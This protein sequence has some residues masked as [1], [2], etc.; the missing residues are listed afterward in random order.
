MVAQSEKKDIP[1]SIVIASGAGGEFLLRC[2]DFLR[3]QAASPG[4]EV[5]VVDCCGEEVISRISKEHP[6]VRLLRPDV[7]NHRP[8]VPESPHRA[9]A[10]PRV[11]WSPSS[12]STVSSLPTGSR[13]SADRLTRRC[14]D[15]RPYPGQRL[16]S[17]PRWVVYFSEYHNYMPPWTAGERTM[18]N[19][20]NIAY[21]REM[22]LKH[23]DVLG[24]GFWEVVLHPRLSK[25]GRFRSIPEMGV[26]HTGPFAYAYYLEQRYLLSRVWTGAQRQNVNS[27]RRLLYLVV[28]PVLPVLLLA[29]IA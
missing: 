25:E 5:I 28:A 19:G 6:Y 18:L 2:L 29:R 23:L 3:S 4:V 27:G 1:L 7:S 16:R 15:R 10:K 13:R 17:S 9:C 8:S 12:R 20:A 22:L 21:P 14:G 26:R 24:Q 11:L